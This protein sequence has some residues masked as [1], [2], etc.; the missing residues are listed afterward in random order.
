MTQERMGDK[1]RQSE[2]QKRD[3]KKERRKYGNCF[4]TD[5]GIYRN[6]IPFPDYVGT[7]F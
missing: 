3:R 1:D 6:L 2:G 5:A 7:M 4:Q